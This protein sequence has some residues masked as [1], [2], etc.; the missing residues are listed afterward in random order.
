MQEYE[1]ENAITHWDL[2][3]LPESFAKL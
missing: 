3:E 1:K 2:V